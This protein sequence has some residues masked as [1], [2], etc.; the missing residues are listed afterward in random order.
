MCRCSAGLE[1][2]AFL[3]ASDWGLALRPEHRQS[4]SLICKARDM[5][6][7]FAFPLACRFLFTVSTDRSHGA[8]PNYYSAVISNL[9]G[10]VRLRRVAPK[11]VPAN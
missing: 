2:L 8:G 11:I 3:G 5:I 4:S 9:L 1:T 6:M 7:H 10:L